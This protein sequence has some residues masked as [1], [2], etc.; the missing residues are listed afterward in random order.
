MSIRLI[1]PIFAGSS[2]RSLDADALA[3]IQA[4]EAADG[5][6]LEAAVKVAIFNLFVGL[7]S[8]GLWSQIKSACILAGAR[9]R[10]G[11]MVPLVGLAPTSVGFVDADYGRKTGLKGDAIS[12]RLDTNRNNNADPQDS[13]HL[14]VWVTQLGTLGAPRS[15]MG[16]GAGTSVGTNQLVYDNAAAVSRI[17]G[18]VLSFTTVANHRSLGLFAATRSADNAGVQFSNGVATPFS[19]T[20]ALPFNENISVFSRGAASRAFSDVGIGFYSAGE[21]INPTL[22]N[23]RLG[24]F[25]AAIGAAIP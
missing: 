4:V 2:P 25:F 3:Y 7:K 14:A 12:K 8:D 19:Y 10:L 5:Q 6:A 17:R 15:L 9:T 21:N 22:L 16:A 13:S 20:S 1:N 23:A 24:T 18:Q 11:A